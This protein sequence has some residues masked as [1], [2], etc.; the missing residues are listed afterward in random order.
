MSNIAKE[1]GCDAS[2]F[3]YR[4]KRIYSKM[5]LKLYHN[6]FRYRFVSTRNQSKQPR[7]LKNAKVSPEELL[8]VEN[9]IPKKR[10]ICFGIEMFFHFRFCY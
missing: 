4:D 8:T 10:L 6:G 1:R 5:K 9:E 2:P 7:N 3:L